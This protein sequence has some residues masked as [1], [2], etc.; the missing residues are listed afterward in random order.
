MRPDPPLCPKPDDGKSMDTPAS[1]PER[2][3]RLEQLREQVRN[4]TYEVDSKELAKTLIKRHI[5]GGNG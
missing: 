3:E 5:A 2:Q 1:A 4:G